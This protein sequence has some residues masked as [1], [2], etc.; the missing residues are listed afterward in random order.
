MKTSKSLRTFSTFR[1]F[2]LRIFNK[3][4]L[5]FFVL[6]GIEWRFLVD[7]DTERDL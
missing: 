3:E 1:S 2:L 5:I 6:L 7:Y 4:F